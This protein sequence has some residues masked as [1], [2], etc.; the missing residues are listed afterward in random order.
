MIGGQAPSAYLNQLQTHKAV[1]LDNASLDAILM[2]HCLDPA[3]LRQ[4]DFESFITSRKRTLLNKIGAVMGK[5]IVA[6]DEIVPEDE[7][8]EDE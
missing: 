7:A 4:D 5:Q 2:T 1:Q 3:M 6:S 8:D